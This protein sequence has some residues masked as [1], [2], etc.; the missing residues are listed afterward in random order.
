MLIVIGVVFQETPI[1]LALTLHWGHTTKPQSQ[2]PGI[3][4]HH[5][6]GK[7][8]YTHARTHTHFVVL[9]LSMTGSDDPLRNS[10]HT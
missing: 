5:A 4:K 10:I 6:E 2:L 1:T 8:K 3:M 9:M 7:Q